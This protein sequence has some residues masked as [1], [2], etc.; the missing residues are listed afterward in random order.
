MHPD[1]P[2]N[3]RAINRLLRPK[4]SLPLSLPMD[5]ALENVLELINQPECMG[6]IML[7]VLESLRCWNS[8]NS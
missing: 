4:A 7:M 1:N 6:V 3:I 2:V 5:A 8:K